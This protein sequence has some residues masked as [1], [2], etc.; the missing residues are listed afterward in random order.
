MTDS[1]FL[2]GSERSALL[3]GMQADIDLRSSSADGR[4]PLVSKKSTHRESCVCCHDGN[5]DNTDY[6]WEILAVLILPGF[7][8]CAVASQLH[9]PDGIVIGVDDYDRKILLQTVS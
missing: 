5:D 8:L 6:R 2:A 1:F 7:L 4:A 9:S 3:F